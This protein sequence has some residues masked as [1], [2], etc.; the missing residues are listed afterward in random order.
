MIFEFEI[1]NFGLSSINDIAEAKNNPKITP[2]F[3]VCDCFSYRIVQFAYVIFFLVI[4]VKGGQTL[5][6]SGSP[7][8]AV[9]YCLSGVILPQRCHIASAVSYCLSGVLDTA[10]ALTF[11]NNFAN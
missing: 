2:I 4:P 7:D 6:N 1:L 3:F 5:S 9:S 10:E 8:S 11:S